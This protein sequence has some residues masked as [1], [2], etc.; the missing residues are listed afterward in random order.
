MGSRAW[1]IKED[2]YNEL[3]NLG[4]ASELLIKGPILARGYLN[5]TVKIDAQFIWNPAWM[6]YI[7]GMQSQCRLYQTGDL[8]KY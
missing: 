4:S 5:N 1:I 8:A 6:S 2:N 7:K 3:A